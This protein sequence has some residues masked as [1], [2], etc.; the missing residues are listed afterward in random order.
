M[1]ILK[2]FGL[3]L[4][5][6]VALPSLL[7]A[8]IIDVDVTGTCDFNCTSVGLGDGDTFAGIV[9]VNDDTFLPGEFDPS[10][11]ISYSF[12][13]GTFALSESNTAISN[14]LIQ[15]GSTP[16]SISAIYMFAFGSVD[17]TAPGPYLSLG[18]DAALS[19]SGYAAIDAFYFINGDGSWGGSE[20]NLASLTTN[21]FGPPT[22]VPLPP[23]GLLLMGSLLGFAALMR[24]RHA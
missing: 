6:L 20:G 11:I 4:L 19:S 7:S 5:A 12:A 16:G 1:S 21:P 14:N 8:A 15:W 2:P 9:S 18:A 10:A 23:A 24:R 22:P 17:P 3:S 13:F